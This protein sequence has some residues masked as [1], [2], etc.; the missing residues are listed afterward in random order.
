MPS[1]ESAQVRDDVA[2]TAL[3]VRERSRRA[4]PTRVVH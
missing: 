1:V 2:I 4:A 3:G